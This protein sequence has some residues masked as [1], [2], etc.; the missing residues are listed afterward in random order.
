MSSRV[1]PSTRDAIF[2]ELRIPDLK[3]ASEAVKAAEALSGFLD[4]GEPAPGSEP[5]SSRISDLS[6][7][8]IAA[9][10]AIA[11]DSPELQEVLLNALPASERGVVL[12]LMPPPARAAALARAGSGIANDPEVRKALDDQLKA[13]AKAADLAT[14]PADSVA[15]ELAVLPAEEAGKILASMP[16]PVQA[17][18]AAAMDASPRQAMIDAMRPSDGGKVAEAAKAAAAA[19]KLAPIAKAE[20]KALRLRAVNPEEAAAVLGAMPSAEE[21]AAVLEKLP[22]SARMSILAAA[23]PSDRAA[24]MGGVSAMS[25]AARAATEDA[26]SAAAEEQGGAEEPGGAMPDSGAARPPPTLD[27]VQDKLMA[28]TDGSLIDALIEEGGEDH[29]RNHVADVLQ[30]LVDSG[31]A[32]GVQLWRVEPGMDDV[33]PPEGGSVERAEAL[34]GATA[35]PEGAAADAGEDL[36]VDSDDE[37]DGASPEAPGAA[38]EAAD[39]VDALGGLEADVWASAVRADNPPPAAQDMNSEPLLENL[40]QAVAKAARS[41]KPETTTATTGETL[42]VSPLN[43]RKRN[44]A[45][46][47]AH[48]AVVFVAPKMNESKLGDVNGA[49]EKFVGE[50]QK[51]ERTEAKNILQ[52]LKR[53]NP[54]GKQAIQRLLMGLGCAPPS[55]Y[56]AVRH[57]AARYG[58]APGMASGY[59][60]P[61]GKSSGYGAYAPPTAARR[62]GSLAPLPRRRPRARGRLWKPPPPPA[63]F[64]RGMNVKTYTYQFGRRRNN[65]VH[66]YRMAQRHVQH[67]L[68]QSKLRRFLAELRAYRKPPGSVMKIACALFLLLGDKTVTAHLKGGTGGIPP[69]TGALWSDIV[70][71]IVLMPTKPDYLVLRM[72]KARSVPANDSQRKGAMDLV[73]DISYDDARGGSKAAAALWK[74]VLLVIAE[75]EK[76]VRAAAEGGK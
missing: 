19:K 44:G 35:A 11:S 59:K 48:G 21:R 73:A 47:K 14:V 51:V 75:Q 56:G 12:A 46:G 69:D 64:E 24:A 1:R 33:Q 45:K 70:R 25:S 76:A 50:L 58:K 65:M 68:H 67:Q 18:V 10:A 7:R 49:L 39:E 28:L 29:L 3:V 40:R 54:K 43:S 4:D 57:H 5:A 31:M 23:E 36:P 71:G 63:E 66:A 6:E 62:V 41:G 26:L 22:L 72:E 34:E 16:E 61:E 2:A 42:V 30:D 55:N 53:G 15:A 27:D 9:A 74:W 13:N 38:S 52:Q 8:E 32:D 60:P 17:R 20:E 37:D